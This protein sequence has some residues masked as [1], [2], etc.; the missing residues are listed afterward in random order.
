[1]DVDLD[2]LSTAPQQDLDSSQ[3]TFFTSDDSSSVSYS[4]QVDYE[5]NTNEEGK[6]HLAGEGLTA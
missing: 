4:Q 1:V 6:Y 3:N 5:N 2:L